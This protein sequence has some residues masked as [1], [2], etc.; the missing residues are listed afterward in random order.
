M[1]LIDFEGKKPKVSRSAFVAPNATLIGDVTVGSNS[2]I[3]YGAVLRGDMH[4]IRIGKNVS[5]QDNSVMHGTANKY[6]TIIG[7]NVS[8][9]HNAIVHGC[10]IGSDCLIGMGSVILE[11]A[12]IG[13]GCIVAAGAVVLEGTKV[14]PNSI[15]MGMPAR[16][17]GKTEDRH[18]LRITNN[19]KEYVR[20]KERYMNKG[21]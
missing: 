12:R 20:L 9:G 10:I 6:P 3:W 17:K 19:W 11:G 13:K 21:N 15:V 4:Y 1:A 14:P 16:V 18:R 5:V 7:D 2:S 8:I